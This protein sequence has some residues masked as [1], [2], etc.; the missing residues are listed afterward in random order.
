V[1]D[2]YGAAAHFTRVELIAACHAAID[3]DFSLEMLRP[4]D[5]M[6]KVRR[7]SRDETRIQL[8]LQVQAVILRSFIRAVSRAGDH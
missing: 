8:S 7:V 6:S 3:E 1:L 5:K 4:S 2:A